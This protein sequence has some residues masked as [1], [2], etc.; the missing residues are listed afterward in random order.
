MSDVPDGAQLS[1]DGQ[2][3]WDGGQWQPVGGQGSG[4]GGQ[5]GG[6]PGGDEDGGQKG[7]PAF[8]FVINDHLGIEPES[9]EVATANAPLKAAFTVCN[10]GTAAGSAHVVIFVNGSDSGIVWDSPT[11]EP[12]QY[13]TPDGDGSVKGIPGQ[14]EGEHK[15]EMWVTPVGS[16]AVNTITTLEIGPPEN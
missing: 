14:S 4:D 3:W 5:G 9:G 12:G 13:A 15:F 11:V 8:D 7:E 6:Q 2:W 16:G 10:T 1:E